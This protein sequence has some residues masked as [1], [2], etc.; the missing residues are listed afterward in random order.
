MREKSV[1]VQFFSI[2]WKTVP[3]V[4]DYVAQYKNKKPVQCQCNEIAELES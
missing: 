4:K 3:D 1:G 2:T